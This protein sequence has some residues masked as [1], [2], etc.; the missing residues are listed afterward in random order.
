MTTWIS[1]TLM[2][3]LGSALAACASTTMRTADYDQSCTRDADCV[4]V[5]EGNLCTMC[6]NI[7]TINKQEEA[8]YD[9]DLERARAACGKRIIQ[10]HPCSG[11]PVACQRGRCVIAEIG[12]TASTERRAARCTHP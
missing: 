12:P 11:S 2:A 5:F 4:D 8:R 7:N 3:A 1:F 6:C 10:C 9:R